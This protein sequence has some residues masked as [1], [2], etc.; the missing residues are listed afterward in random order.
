MVNKRRW[1]YIPPEK[2]LA[3]TLKSADRATRDAQA[4]TG[5]EREQAVRVLKEEVAFLI[6]QVAYGSGPTVARSRTSDPAVDDAA[7]RWEPFSAAEDVTVRVVAPESGSVIV[8]VSAYCRATA[9][10]RITSNDAAVVSSQ[11]VLGFDVLR[12]DNSVFMGADSG[13]AATA[14]TE[15]AAWLNAPAYV[16]SGSTA[17]CRV[18]VSG[19]VPGV[20]YRFRTRM[21]SK[22]SVG[23]ATYSYSYQNA[24]TNSPRLA[25]TNIR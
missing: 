17:F 25:I 6:D 23:S 20:E 12:P 21:G 10:A 2:R 19:L 18:V 24:L 22:F 1:R 15:V 3:E 4:P 7:L 14:F 5:T 8:E 11:T 9:A 16:A 13:R